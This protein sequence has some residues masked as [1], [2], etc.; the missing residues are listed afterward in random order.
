MS[1][2]RGTE[3]GFGFK[4]KQKPAKFI[5]F[6]DSEKNHQKIVFSFSR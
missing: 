6:D 1:F 3:L 4:P 5:D 2:P